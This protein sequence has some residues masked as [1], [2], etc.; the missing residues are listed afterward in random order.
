VAWT[1]RRPEELSKARKRK[2]VHNWY[3][4]KGFRFPWPVCSNCGLVF[5]KNDRTRKAA[6]AACEWD[7]DS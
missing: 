5:L 3:T 7:E 1:V 4:I 6:K 2:G